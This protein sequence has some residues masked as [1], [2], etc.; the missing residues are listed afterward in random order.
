MK[1]N[2]NHMK[3]ELKWTFEIL[4]YQQLDT[5]IFANVVYT[6]FFTRPL[7][8][9]EADQTETAEKDVTKKCD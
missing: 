9:S 4:E 6:A 1:G 2:R 3:K 7:Y 8:D 5:P